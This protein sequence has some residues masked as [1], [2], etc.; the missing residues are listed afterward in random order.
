MNESDLYEKKIA[1]NTGEQ[2]QSR[3]NQVKTH[4]TVFLLLL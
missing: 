4:T 3:S 2:I 1:A